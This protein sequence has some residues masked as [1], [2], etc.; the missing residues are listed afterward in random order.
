MY[1]FHTFGY[2]TQLFSF[3]ESQFWYVCWMLINGPVRSVQVLSNQWVLV[4]KKLALG[5]SKCATE[6]FVRHCPEKRVP[7]E[8]FI[9]SLSLVIPVLVLVKKLNEYPELVLFKAAS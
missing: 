5:S 4:G 1:S 9:W 7:S 3:D 8:R 2:K 6:K